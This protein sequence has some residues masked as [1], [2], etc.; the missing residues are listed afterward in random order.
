[1][2]NNLNLPKKSDDIL[3][4]DLFLN[5]NNLKPVVAVQLKYIGICLIYNRF[6]LI[7]RLVELSNNNFKNLLKPFL[8]SM[9]NLKKKNEILKKI[10]LFYDKI[11]RVIFINSKSHIIN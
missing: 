4:I 2:K 11:I 9:R 5:K 3:N 6:D 8:D 7:E 10:N 1:V